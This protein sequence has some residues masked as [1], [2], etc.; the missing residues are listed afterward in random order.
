[1]DLAA[2]I[3]HLVRVPVAGVDCESNGFHAY[4]EK[5]CLI[6]VAT[7]AHDCVIDPL[8]DLDLGPLLRW[9]ADPEKTKVMQ[10]AEFDVLSF[11]RDYDVGIRG[12]FDTMH[13]ARLVGRRK[14]GLAALAADIVGMKMDKRFQRHDWGRR[15]VDERAVEYARADSRCLLPIYDQLRKE[16]DAAGVAEAL[17]AACRK[18]EAMEPKPRVFDPDGFVRLKGFENLSPSGRRIVRRVFRW[19]EGVAKERN[20]AAFRILNPSV[21]IAV[22]QANPTD[23]RALR[24]VRGVPKWLPKPAARELFAQILAAA[25]DDD[26]GARK[27]R[28]RRRR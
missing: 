27:R 20:V 26:P 2:W 19:R 18:V 11:K 12:L 14:L 24:R 4:R 13:A 1:M 17:D 25:N 28:P 22:A 5:V 7:E 3:E 23:M 16:V 10:G 15:P 8:A 9:L 21:L 6:Q